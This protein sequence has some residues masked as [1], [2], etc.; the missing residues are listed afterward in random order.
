MAGYPCQSRPAVK[1]VGLRRARRGSLIDPICVARPKLPADSRATDDWARA[2][3]PGP[4]DAGP[5]F[6]QRDGLILE[7]FEPSKDRSAIKPFSANTKPRIGLC[8]VCVS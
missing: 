6:S 8:C 1:C 3:G 2:E 5:G 7:I 4:A